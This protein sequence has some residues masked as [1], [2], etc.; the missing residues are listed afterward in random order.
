MKQRGD[1]KM[2]WNIDVK[3]QEQ[4]LMAISHFLLSVFQFAADQ[5][6]NVFLKDDWLAFS[7]ENGAW[8]YRLYERDTE[9]GKNMRRAVDRLFRM[10][11]GKRERI[12]EAI[13]HDMEFMDRQTWEK[14]RFSLESDQLSDTAQKILKDFFGYFYDVVLCTTHFHLNEL[15]SP[16][17]S[18]KELVKDYFKGKNRKIRRICPVCL[19]M[20]PDGKTGEDIAH[21]FPKSK[22][23]CLCL[24][25]YNLYFC[26][27]ACSSRFK[28]TRSPLKGKQRNIGSIFLPY[29]DTVKEQV[30]LEFENLQDKDSEVVKML[31]A[32]D[33]TAD[34]EEKIKDFNR[35][36]SL[37]ER[38]RGQLEE[39]YMNLYCWY[40]EKRKE[41][42]K[43]MSLE[44]LEEYL[45]EDI[46]RNQD[47]ESVQPER[48]LEGEYMKWILKKQL[49]AFCAEVNH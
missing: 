3:E 24:H 18:R 14:D 1:E 28:G 44:Q 41:K 6:G 47:M 39:C 26:C 16:M 34:T 9:N 10:E 11:Q 46:K 30:Q 49:K 12:Y 31:P 33:G 21:Y 5:P 13:K 32:G 2:F 19:N 43:E 42:D 36:F 22:Y 29:L 8:F 45:K 40:Q 48:Y 23:P 35:L 37:E 17:Y 20:I 27:S 38:W 15:S 25:P 4:D 7:P